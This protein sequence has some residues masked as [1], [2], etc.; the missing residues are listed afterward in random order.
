ML[1]TRELLLERL[2]RQVQQSDRI[3]IAVAWANDCSALEQLCQFAGPDKRLR[4]IVGIWGNASHPNALRTIQKCAHLRIVTSAEGLFHPKLYLFHLPDRCVGWIG[5]ANLTGPGFEQ[6]E[7]LVLEFSDDGEVAQWFEE[8]WNSLGD[9]DTTRSILDKYERD[10]KPPSAPPRSPQLSE[11][12]PTLSEI[13]DMAG[14]LADWSSFVAAIVEADEY[15]GYYWKQEHPVTGEIGSWSNTIALGNAVVLRGEWS[16]LSH[17]DRYLILGRGD[18]GLLGSMRGAG[19]ANNVFKEATRSNLLV[20]RKI[21]MALQPVIDA[22]ASEFAGAACAFIGELEGIDG[23]AGA[24]ATRFLALARPDRAISVNNGSRKR[25]SELTGL[26]VSSLSKAPHGRG[27]SYMDLLHWFEDRDWYSSP[28][29]RDAG[30]RLL[31]SRRAA[32]F[33]AFVYEPQE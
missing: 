11:R 26:P 6:N 15:W 3:D 5:S 29:P 23:F 19:V 12:I 10:W 31:A 27:R 20:R 32:T 30:E 7:E 18:Y 9:A 14:G 2:S 8:R 33:D 28:D 1:L 13:Y 22:K 17:L 4:T 16:N 25:L 24:L 21:R